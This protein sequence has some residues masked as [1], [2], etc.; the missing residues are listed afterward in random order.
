MKKDQA[1]ECYR[2]AFAYVSENCAEELEWVRNISPDTF[3]NMTCPEFLGEG[4]TQRIGRGRMA[5]M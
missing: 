5:V 1:R 4:L 3:E 2:L